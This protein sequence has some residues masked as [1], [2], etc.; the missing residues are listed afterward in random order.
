MGFFFHSISWLWILFFW[1][2]C[3]FSLGTQ[4]KIEILFASICFVMNI[5]F[6]LVFIFHLSIP[7]IGLSRTFFIFPVNFPINIMKKPV[8]FVHSSSNTR[9]TKEEK[10]R[11]H[12]I[13]FCILPIDTRTLQS[14]N[15]FLPLD[16]NNLHRK[17]FKKKEQN[18]E[19]CSR[20]KW[21]QDH[22]NG[23]R[24]G[25]RERTNIH[26]KQ[27]KKTFDRWKSKT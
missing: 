26:E 8:V 7:L 27:N 3:S 24:S 11:I 2:C 17:I 1:C 13:Q 4:L 5:I 22:V 25:N 21:A 10:N 23:K 14:I 15:I 20:K 6:V 16:Y 19:N 18:V 9:K 12:N